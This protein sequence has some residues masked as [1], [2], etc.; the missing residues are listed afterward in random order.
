MSCHFAFGR[1]D[2]IAD[3]GCGEAKLARSVKHRVLS[4]DLRAIN[5]RV[6]VADISKLPLKVSYSH[7]LEA[8]P[9]T[10]HDH[11]GRLGT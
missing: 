7:I 11:V 3:L 1:K 2:T 5:P 8:V 4:F 9:C 6:K 10:A